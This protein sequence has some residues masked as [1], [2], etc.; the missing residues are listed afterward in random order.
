MTD[1]R[2]FD[3]MSRRSQRFA[4]GV[5]QVWKAPLR[6]RLLDAL[7]VVVLVAL[8]S[9]FGAASSWLMVGLL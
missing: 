3:A 5:I 7:K 8:V 2:M 4:P 9:A 1:T 6:R